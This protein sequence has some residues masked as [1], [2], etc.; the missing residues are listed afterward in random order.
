MDGMVVH[1]LGE[2]PHR[3]AIFHEVGDALPLN[4]VHML[5]AMGLVIEP[6]CTPSWT[7]GREYPW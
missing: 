1:I 5:S 2:T 7:D 3:V 4:V 6:A